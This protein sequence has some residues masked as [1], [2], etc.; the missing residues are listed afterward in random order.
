MRK[1]LLLLAALVAC[2]SVVKDEF[3][4][5]YAEVTRPPQP[6]GPDWDPDIAVRVAPGIV[7]A[8]IAAALQGV[9]LSTY[10]EVPGGDLE[11]K[12]TVENLRIRDPKTRCDGC[13]G[14]KSALKGTVGFKLLTFAGKANVRIHVGLDTRLHVRQEA[15]GWV[16]LA[17]PPTVTEIETDLDVVNRTVSDFIVSPLA[18]WVS[19]TIGTRVQPIVLA[20]LGQIDVPLQ[21]LR[22]SVQN[23]AVA[24]DARTTAPGDQVVGEA[25]EPGTGWT[26]RISAASVE[27][28]ARQ[29]AFKQGSLGF[30]VWIDPRGIDIDDDT[31]LLN[32]RLWRVSGSGWW[33]DYEVQA[34]MAIDGGKLQLT[35]RDV[36][37]TDASPNAGLV[38]P[39]AAL[40]QG[41][42]LDVISSAINTSVPT[43]RTQDIQG[44][45]ST[46]E[47]LLL[48]RSEQDLLMVGRATFDGTT[49]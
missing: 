11:P 24:L 36:R 25:I 46:W 34:D 48:N 19:T 12:L 13:I 44:T 33:R 29:A 37:Q 3:Q 31:F 6:I 15:D 39:I 45:R 43:S 30:G 38:D 26:A 23:G 42:I 28:A 21:A 16:V 10:V 14:L 41:K 32:L 9:D 20:R 17:D 4:A 7:E 35:P 27:A 40:L 2:S 1:S 47:I 8:A 18:Q 5:T 49:P 22:V